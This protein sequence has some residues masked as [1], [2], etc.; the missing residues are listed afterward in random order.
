MD[1]KRSYGE[2]RRIAREK[3]LWWPLSKDIAQ[4]ATAIGI[5]CLHEPNKSHPRDWENPG[6]VKVLWKRDGQTVYH[7]AKTR[8]FIY[9]PL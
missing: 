3:A 6:R 2:Q 9:S 4:A 7:R 1:A 8:Q 5:Q